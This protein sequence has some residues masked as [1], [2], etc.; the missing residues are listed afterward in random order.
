MLEAVDRLDTDD[1]PD[2]E[3]C[4]EKQEDVG[5][6]SR[7]GD[8]V[9]EVGVRALA[10][11]SSAG[12]LYNAD[13]STTRCIACDDQRLQHQMLSLTGLSSS[14]CELNECSRDTIMLLECCLRNRN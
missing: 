14:L 2:K 8:G 13:G 11:S 3:R 1:W 10:M 9:F 7:L 5:V 4:E 6:G 12:M